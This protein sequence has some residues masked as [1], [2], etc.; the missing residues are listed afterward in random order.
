M[1]TTT[2]NT[3]NN[4]TMNNANNTL[5]KVILPFATEIVKKN[6]MGVEIL[7]ADVVTDMK[8]GTKNNR[9][10]AYN[11]FFNEE[12]GTWNV[13][14]ETLYI[15]ATLGRVYENS[16]ENRSDNTESYDTEKPKG[17]NWVQFPYLLQADNNPNMLYL[18][19]SEN[20]NT[21]RETTYFVG[22]RVATKEE[23]EI[24]KAHLP[25]K[26]HTCQK[27]IEY[28]VKEENQAIVK[29]FTLSKI[30]YIKFGEKKLQLA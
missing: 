21:K 27:Q 20:K 5:A 25:Q 1:K 7:F 10:E 11:R 17:K 3:T 26:N 15:N 12:K 9:S 16:V 13:R 14:K 28:G 18:R 30:K 19:I 24:I 6:A 22:E 4:N 8:K 29:D 2:N 23:V